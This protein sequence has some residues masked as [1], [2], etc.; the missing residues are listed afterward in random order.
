MRYLLMTCLLWAGCASTAPT[1]P[2]HDTPVAVSNSNNT[3]A[4]R[5]ATFNTALSRPT[6]GEL[7]RALSTPS[8]PKARLVAE[9]LQRTRP[10]VVLLQ[11][12][13]YDATGQSVRNFIT[14]YL[15][16]PQ[17][18]AQP[19]TYA[20]WFMPEVNTGVPVLDDA[21][22]PVD[23]N[24]DG[25]TGTPHDAHGWGNYSGHYGMVL[26]SRWPIDWDDTA[27]GSNSFRMQEAAAQSFGQEALDAQPAAARP[28]I[29]AS[30]K[31]HLA[32]A[33]KVPTTN[34]LPGRPA[35]P[36]GERKEDAGVPV[37]VIFAHP[38]PPVF[39]GPEDR[40]GHRNALEI[41]MLSR[42]V[43]EAYFMAQ[44]YEKQPSPLIVL[45]DMNADPHDGESRPGA[46]QQLIDHPQLQDP[47]PG[48]DGGTA[49]ASKQSGINASHRTDPRTDTADWNDDPNQGPGN[50][51]VDYVLPSRDLIVLEAGVYWPPPGDSRVYLNEASDHRL[52]WVDLAVPG[53]QELS[54]PSDP[55]RIP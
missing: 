35:P 47:Q 12:F 17:N 28:F 51:R 49:W 39:D 33:I 11:E 37:G 26:L 25:Q 14:H 50:L 30:S 1:A 29:R 54:I 8:D 4:F 7:A 44:A 42:Y 16:T 48:S 22:E 32:V 20:H 9:V 34:R 31:T 5:V 45:G 3:D 53:S 27:S 36:R 41:N 21:G 46:V 18:G 43:E 55:D 15:E 6:S 10:D 19:I 52:V 13:D 2:L 38:T 23:V 24:G 40:N